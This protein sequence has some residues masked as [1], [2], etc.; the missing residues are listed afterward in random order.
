MPKLPPFTPTTN[1]RPNPPFSRNYDRFDTGTLP[2]FREF[3]VAHTQSPSDF[4]LDPLGARG[5]VMY[6][7]EHMKYYQQGSNFPSNSVDHSVIPQNEVLARIQPRTPVAAAAAASSSA[8][9]SAASSGGMQKQAIMAAGN[10]AN[11]ATH[12]VF[13][14]LNNVQ[15]GKNQAQ[16]LED[17]NG[18]GSFST[19]M[20][21]Q[22]HSNMKYAAA[23]Q[24]LKEQQNIMDLTTAA[25][26][27]LGA[28]A[29]YIGGKFHKSSMEKKLDYNTAFSSLGGRM[30][31]DK[32][33]EINSSSQLSNQN[34]PIEEN[35]SE[36]K[37]RTAA[38]SQDLPSESRSRVENLPS[39]S[40]VDKPPSYE[41]ANNSKQD[42]MEMSPDRSIK[43]SQP[44]EMET[45]V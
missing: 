12:G 26:G 34:S 8:E 22:L 19:N 2:K 43:I 33:F 28:I 39:S 42:S 41:E 16:Y 21:T 29:G 7:S 3:G 11:T 40:K 17:I 18:R 27:P 5:D 6:S 1:P 25:A 32:P 15:S 13:S 9:T 24:T 4:F 30:N 10:L 37:L 20:H 14:M 31:P 23:N 36:E 38:H 44:T 45:S 35:V